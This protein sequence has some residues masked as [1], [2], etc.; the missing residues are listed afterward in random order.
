[1]STKKMRKHNN[2]AG[3]HTVVDQAKELGVA[4]ER[5]TLKANKRKSSGKK[6]KTKIPGKGLAIVYAFGYCFS[7]FIACNYL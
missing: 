7:Y 1:M 4:L 3:S 6:F 5:A 2:N